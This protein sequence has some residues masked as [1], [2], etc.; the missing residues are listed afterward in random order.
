M[1]LT[2][3]HYHNMKIEI[4]MIQLNINNNHN[5]HM[6]PMIHKSKNPKE[7][8]FM[9]TN[10]LNKLLK[11]LMKLLF[12]IIIISFKWFFSI[13]KNSIMIAFP[14]LHHSLKLKPLNSLSNPL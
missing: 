1:Y 4:H 8:L 5:Y 10:L 9:E 12:K 6:V 3:F 13:R 14:L 7:I 2:L 11:I